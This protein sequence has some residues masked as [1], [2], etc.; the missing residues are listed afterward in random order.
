MN[1]S[2][3]ATFVGFVTAEKIADVV[4]TPKFEVEELE[5]DLVVA[6]LDVR[7]D[8]IG[9][10][11]ADLLGRTVARADLPVAGDADPARIVADGVALLRRTARR[12][13]AGQLHTVAFGA[14]GLIEAIDDSS[15]KPGTS[16]PGS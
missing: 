16:V 1:V 3:T 6:G 5:T 12:A 15:R 9:V 2:P 11:I 10:E 13:G 4:S 8:S 7:I 14:P